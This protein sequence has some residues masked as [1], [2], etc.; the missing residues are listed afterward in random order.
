MCFHVSHFK[1][2]LKIWSECVLKMEWILLELMHC[3]ERT[4]VLIK[5]YKSTG[6][7]AAA[8][9]MYSKYSEVP[10]EGPYPWG[11]W[12]DIVMAHKQPLNM[13]VQS[14]TI[15]DKGTSLSRLSLYLPEILAC[16]SGWNSAVIEGS[17]LKWIT[18]V[19]CWM[20]LCIAASKK[21]ACLVITN[22]LFY[23]DFL[24]LHAC[25]TL[26]K[27]SSVCLWR[28]VIGLL[29][30]CCRQWCDPEDTRGYTWRNHSILDWPFSIIRYLCYPRGTVGEGPEVFLKCGN[31]QFYYNTILLH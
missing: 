3:P 13:F 18:A 8:K 16:V 11:K 23:S 24:Y 29:C 12:R 21:N 9:V 7:V 28:L 26:M 20:W 27:L 10:D 2:S 14:N 15:L 22:T 30:V 1:C 4:C 17:V 25:C 6:D 31:S 19:S 5:V